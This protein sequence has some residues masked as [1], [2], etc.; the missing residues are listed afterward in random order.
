MQKEAASIVGLV[1]KLTR[2]Q[3]KDKSERYKTVK[4][5]K[6]HKNRFRLL[7][8]DHKNIA[9]SDMKEDFE[10][11]F[12]KMKDGLEDLRQTMI[13][14]IYDFKDRVESCDAFVKELEAANLQKE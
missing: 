13:T 9:Y 4:R 7:K 5:L 1:G 14:Q 11:Q 2:L 6:R 3:F 8:R 12:L 10:R